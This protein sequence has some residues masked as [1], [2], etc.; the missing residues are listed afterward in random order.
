MFVAA[1][2][3]VP[4]IYPALFNWSIHMFII[5]ELMFLVHSFP[6]RYCENASIIVLIPALVPI[7][8]LFNSLFLLLFE[9]YSLFEHSM[10]CSSQMLRAE[11]Q[12]CYSGEQLHSFI[13]LYLLYWLMI[14]LLI[15]YKLFIW[16]WLYIDTVL[17]AIHTTFT[18][19]HVYS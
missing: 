5:Y 12:L 1:V 14:L 10:S 15:F 18:W 3:L 13:K 8:P 11:N 9:Y 4:F 17:I 16:V 2:F 6:G 7:T 19:L